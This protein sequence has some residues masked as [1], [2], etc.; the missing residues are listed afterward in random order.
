[1]TDTERF[2][3]YALAFEKAYA[4]EGWGELERFFCE[5]ASRRAS[6]G[7]AKLDV[8]SH[9]RTEVLT[10]LRRGVESVDKRFDERLPEILVGPVERDGAVWM[11]WRLTL[12][13]E[14]LPD[15]LVEG[16]HGTYFR[17]GKIVRIEEQLAPGVAE[18]VSRYFE[19]HEARLKSDRSPRGAART[20][21]SAIPVSPSVERM[22]TLVETYAAAKSRADVDGALAVCS[23]S[24]RLETVSFG[25]TAEGKDEARFHLDAFFSAFPD[26]GVVVDGMAFGDGAL[27][28]WGSA[29]MTMQGEILGIPP[30]GRSVTLPIFC[31]FS[32][33]ADGIT[34]E[35]FFFDL[36][37]LAEGIGVGVGALQA[38]LEPLRG[39]GEA[40]AA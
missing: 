21:T 15:L 39:T 31:K 2:I 25:L 17:D 32:F 12:R 30:T 28:C 37:Q 19:T 22:R 29:S 18:R 34:E 35:R 5:D 33:D 26:Y 1:M 10:E 13:R 16:D 9:G 23:E 11:D 27:G 38:A 8:D 14:G 6:N 4:D 20:A 3:A 7:G 36:V 40:R 24:F